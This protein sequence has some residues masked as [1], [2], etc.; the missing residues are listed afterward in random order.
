MRYSGQMLAV[1]GILFNIG[2]SCPALAWGDDGHEVVGLVAQSFLM[3][4]VREKVAALLAADTDSLAAHNIAAASTWADKYRDLDQNGARENTRRWHFV[5]IELAEPDI[6]WACFGHPTLPRGTLASNGPAL[7]CVVDKIDEFA[8]ELAAP[9]TDPTERIVALKFLLHFVG[10]LHQPLHASDDHDRGGNDKRVSAAG[11]KAGTLHHYWD[12]DFVDLL[13]PNPKS[14]ATVLIGQI[15]SGDVR[16]WSRGG[17][18][19]WAMES[20]GVAKSD[21]YGRLPTPNGRGSYRLTDEYVAMATRDVATQLSK[22]G[23]R[24]AWLLNKTLG[25]CPDVAA[26]SGR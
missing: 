12:T 15:S 26:C 22:A 20:Y 18:G 1:A 8:A 4:A 2:W 3:P 10:D 23:V 13:G 7:D 14:I 6:D 25:G 16:N 17:T 9:A 21:T 24:L 5:D 19:E 11:L